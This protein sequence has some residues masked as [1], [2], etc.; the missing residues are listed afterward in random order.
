MRKKLNAN[1]EKDKDKHAT[2][3]RAFVKKVGMG[4]LVTSAYSLIS[5]TQ[6]GC[7]HEPLEPTFRGGY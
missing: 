4:I 2:N 1:V 6:F 5:L 7:K 3:R